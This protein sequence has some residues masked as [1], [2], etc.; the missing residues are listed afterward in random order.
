V[1][2]TLR[3]SLLLLGGPP[4]A[5]KTAVLRVLTETVPGCV[6]VDADDVWSPATF[7]Q[8]EHDRRI[9]ISKIA[10]AVHSH[11]DTGGQ[12][13]V[14]AW[15]FAREEMFIPFLDRFTDLVDEVCQLYLVASP[16]VLKKR[17][18]ARG[19]PEKVS[20][21]WSRLDLI[22]RLPFKSIDTSILAPSVVAAE[23]THEMQWSESI[24]A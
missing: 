2:H 12:R 3:R 9:G 4:G 8:R 19:D 5:G 15:V 14:L 16:D 7:A 6:A 18:T 24:G 13:V 21:A 10:D 20:Y 1:P 23:I 22:R 11:F 17:L